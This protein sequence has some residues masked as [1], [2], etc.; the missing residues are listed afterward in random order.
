MKL[1]NKGSTDDPGFIS[2]LDL[3]TMQ[4]RYTKLLAP[5]LHK[6]VPKHTHTK[7]KQKKK[8]D[9]KLQCHYCKKLNGGL[10]MSLQ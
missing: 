10:L 2:Q 3:T 9:D 4:Y 1:L 5:K 8:N 7:K 6:P